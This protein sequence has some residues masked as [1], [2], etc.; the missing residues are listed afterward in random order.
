MTK[1]ITAWKTLLP[2]LAILLVAAA[3][4]GDAPSDGGR[5]SSPDDI[6]KGGTLTMAGTSDVDYMDYGQSY[7]TLGSALFGG[8]TR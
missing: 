7:Y 1:R 6:P 5:A 4:G 2:G 3:C 8:V